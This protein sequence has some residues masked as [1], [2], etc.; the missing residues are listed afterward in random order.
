MRFVPGAPRQRLLPSAPPSRGPGGLC[1][2]GPVVVEGSPFTAV[3]L[4][5]LSAPQ[6][7]LPFLL[8]FLGPGWMWFCSEDVLVEM[9]RERLPHGPGLTR[10][11]LAWHKEGLLAPG[12]GG[13]DD[14][15]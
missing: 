15:A 1:Q 9:L 5:G 10:A 4:G 3:A 14:G 7:P 11:W 12:D 13:V 2:G 6:L 8:L